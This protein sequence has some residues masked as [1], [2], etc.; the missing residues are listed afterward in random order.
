MFEGEG[1][2]SKF[3]DNY[4]YTITLYSVAGGNVGHE[5]VDP[6]SF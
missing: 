4:A 3:E 2:A 1:E 6:G 5:S